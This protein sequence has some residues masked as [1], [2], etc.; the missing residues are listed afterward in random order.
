VIERFD[1]AVIG[2]PDL[3][4][5]M[6]AFRR[7]GFEVAVGGR[8]P[9]L[10]T[11]NAIVRFGL[12]YLELLTVE[13]PDR[14][15]ARGPFGR[16]LLA[17]LGRGSGLVGYVL[18][19]SGLDDEVDALRDFGLGVEGPFEMDRIHPKGGRL[20]WKLVLPGGSP[21]RK[22]WPY[23]IDWI[24]G[25]DELLAWD[26]PGDHAN[27]VS[28]VAGIDLVVESLEEAVGLYERALGLRAADGGRQSP[29]A[30]SRDYQLGSF[31][32]ALRRPDGTGPVAAELDRSGPGP[33]C[34]V[35]ASSRLDQTAEVLSRGGVTTRR[36]PD[37]IDIDPSEAMGVRM[38]IVPA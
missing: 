11:R 2:V 4:A 15:R 30:S 32:L 22:P 36:T 20:E 12:D 13:D 17:F 37:A 14:A 28:G 31:R 7:L 21:W 18:A 29:G 34:L 16:E 9:S 10:G 38:R 8:H 23:L 24:T 19:G 35:L 27:R 26:P 25:E 1:H 6:D 3:D 5:G 33:Y